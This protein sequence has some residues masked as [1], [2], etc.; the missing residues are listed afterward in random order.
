MTG[1]V[2]SVGDQAPA[3]TLKDQNEHN[4]SL[5]G[6]KGRKVLLSF[7]PLAWTSVCEVQMRSLEIKR[8]VFERLNTVAFGLSVDSV[9]S[10]RAWAEYME[11]EET[12][13]LCD[14]WPHGAVAQDYGVFL[15][16]KGVSKRCN[17]LLD[18]MGKVILFK[19]YE[20]LQIPDIEAVIE[21][22]EGQT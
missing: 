13:L 21:F 7:H 10:K 5:G 2:P 16:G 19:E 15:D 17:F 9:Y 12:G 14:F 4:V 11:L 1:K 20:I 3:F 8:P 6:L 22:L 18:E